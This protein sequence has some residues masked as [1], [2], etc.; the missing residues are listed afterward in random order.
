MTDQTTR[1]PVRR[2]LISVSDKTGILEFA[3]E[4]V[5]LNVEILST[6]GTYKLL[7]DNGIAAVEVAD[8]TGFPEM[9]DGRVKTLHPKIHGGILGRRALDGAVM[10]Q[11]GIKPIDLV[12]VN[13]YPFAATVAKPGCDLA[14]AIENIDIG[15]PTMVR[16][17][18]KNHKDVAIVV[19]ASDYAGIVESLKAGG[20]SYAQRF[21]LAL[22]AFEHTAAYDGMIANYLGTIDQAR[23]T[24]STEERGAFPRTFNSQFIK[25]QEMRYGEN[26]HQ[27]AAFY[28][29]AQKGEAS[30][31]TAIQLQG[32]ELSFNNV[33][34]TDAALECVKSFVKPACVIVK[35]ANPCGV[36]VALDSEGG[37]R[38]AYELAYA[39]DTESA[40]GGIIAFN[41][42]LDGAT[43]QA[44]VERQFVEVIIAPKISAEA[45]AVVAAKANVRL[46][47]CGEWP[48]ERSAGWDF[49]R[50]NGG[51]L[52][53]SRDIGMIT[54][55]DL[56]IVTKR[57][58]S[59][60][61]IHDLI[62]AWKVAKFV[63]SN[64]IVYA[65]GR[66]TIGVG[67][68]QM[69]R[70]NSARIAAI[71]AEHAGLQVAGS[72]MASDAFFPF[73][74]GL[75]NAAANGITA[76]I[77]PGGSMRDAEVIAAADEAGIAMVFTGMRHFRH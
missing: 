23:D 76:V 43:A 56:K 38:Q 30:V 11:H 24:L 59:E 73:R 10:E 31:A 9:M 72:V 48:A 57:A 36:A 3:R 29:E 14:D 34:D 67:A 51:L 41:R 58:P 47:E 40:F 25:A 22:K 50:V 27:S 62:F 8:Y 77:Q 63:K 39:T 21:D 42:E 28:V 45:R 64:A 4:L 61:E 69:S 2:A 20:L 5:A 7:K 75:D 60:Q 33:A 52:V 70:V 26:P 37:I 6:G 13:L 54:A 35:H 32:K 65:K 74:D 12:A 55:E 53:Q 19:S 46:L 15:G 71:K 16:S 68:G 1:L 18:A 66:Q 44:I 17:A 49:K